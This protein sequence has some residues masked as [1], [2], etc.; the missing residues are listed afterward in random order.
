MRNYAGGE[1]TWAKA[2]LAAAVAMALLATTVSL[3]VAAASRSAP[4]SADWQ[5]AGRYVVATGSVRMPA[6]APAQGWRVVLQEKMHGRSYLSRATSDLTAEGSSSSFLVSWRAQSQ[7]LSSVVMRVAVF[8]GHR[9]VSH[10]LWRRIAI[11][12]SFSLKTVM[13]RRTVVVVPSVLSSISGQPAGDQTAV[14]RPGA[15]VPTVGAVIVA[16]PSAAAPTGLFATVTAIARLPDGSVRLTTRPAALNEAFSTFR[17]E[18]GG[19]LAELASQTGRDARAHAAAAVG[20]KC[21][22]SGAITPSLSLDLS[23]FIVSAEL[24]TSAASPYLEFS[25][26]ASP[27]VTLGLQTSG[28][29]KCVATFPKQERKIWGPLFVSYQPIV[30][31]EADGSVKLTYAWHPFFSYVLARGRGQ[32]RD[33]RLFNSHGTLTLSGQ[34]HAHARLQVDAS[35]SLAGRAGLEGS[36]T[37]H[38]D[39]TGT[40]VA[41]PPPSRACLTATGAVDYE[42]NAFADVFVAHWSFTL[43]KGDFLSGT[44]FN[45]CTTLTGSGGGSTGSSGGGGGTGG[46][47]PG[48]GGSG[49]SGPGEGPGNGGE[50]TSRHSIGAGERDSCA[51]VAGGHIKCWG[52][53]WDGQLGDGKDREPS[54]PNPV[55]VLS[56]EGGTEVALGS[57]HSCALVAGGHVKCWGE[58]SYGQLGNGEE[59]NDIPTPVEVTGLAGATQIALGSDHSCAL[60][61]GGHVKCWGENHFGEL[62]DGEYVDSATPV[63]VTGLA[64]A[65][66]IVLGGGH[67][68]ALVAGGHVKCWGNG[69]FGELGNGEYI[70]EATPVEVAGLAGAT[71]IVLGTEASCALMASGHITC[72]GENNDGQ[73]GN[74][75]SSELA[76]PSPVEVIGVAGATKIALGVYD[77]CAVVAGGHVQ[78]WGDNYSGQLG[79]GK[80]GEEAIVSP[81]EVASLEGVTDI[82]LGGQHSCAMVTGGHVKCWGS[83]RSGE[84]GDGKSGEEAIPNPVEA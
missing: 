82:V 39:A 15:K 43:A 77:A 10:S 41:T 18:L 54:V 66:Q 14:L 62:G 26:L 70:D 79:N 74:G 27:E 5:S 76:V 69:R 24:D 49:G 17:A 57:V 30:T 6:G 80:H 44:I 1:R 7:A 84:L 9:L 29:T 40:V 37:P 35:V 28:A 34:V 2:L 31:L 61:A 64:G 32:D 42:L 12:H 47:G 8:E 19:S 72:W 13:R 4:M 60:V 48:G 51:L 25:L 46:S 78:C 22:T 83:N 63:E 68:C 36:I 55:E 23:K 3:A 56:L 16:D 11:K 81:V 38:V 20:F 50:T 75:K 59:V 52:E 71:Q 65:T 45:G 73:L 33:E 21:N 58:D 53:N 67:S